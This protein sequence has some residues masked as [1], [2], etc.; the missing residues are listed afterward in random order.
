MLK[1]QSKWPSFSLAKIDKYWYG[2]NGQN[3]LKVDNHGKINHLKTNQ[4]F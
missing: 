2:I 1:I 4:I 3:I